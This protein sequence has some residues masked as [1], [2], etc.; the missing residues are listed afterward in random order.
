[1]DK[2]T[3]FQNK[4]QEVLDVL[5]EHGYKATQMEVTGSKDLVVRILPT[6]Y[7]ILEKNYSDLTRKIIDAQ[8]V[9]KKI[10]DMASESIQENIQPKDACMREI[11]SAAAKYFNI[12]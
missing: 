1:M 10:Y 5:I 8:D 11:K 3:E 6:D 2:M 9:I 7:A 12:P 4:V